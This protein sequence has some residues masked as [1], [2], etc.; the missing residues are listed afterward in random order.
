MAK[1]G[2]TAGLYKVA[3]GLYMGYLGIING[4]ENRN[5]YNGYMSYSLNSLKGGYIGDYIGNYCRGY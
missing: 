2:T 1:N 5:Y 3:Y 4:K